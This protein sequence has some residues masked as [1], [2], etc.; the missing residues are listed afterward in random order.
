VRVLEQIK[1]DLAHDELPVLL[2]G[3]GAGFVYSHL[4]TSHQSTE[5]IACLRAVPNVTIFS[6]ADAAEL[7]ICFDHA[8]RWSGTSYMRIGKADLASVHDAPIIDYHLGDLVP[9]RRAA[10]RD[11][12]LIA[13]GSMVSAAIRIA[14]DL[15]GAE[16]WSVPTL[17]PLNGN[18]LV[19]IAK[20]ARTIVTL[21]EHSVLGGLGAAVCE[22]LSERAPTHVVRIGVNDRFSKLCGTYEYLLREHRLDDAAIA[23]RIR[24]ARER[25]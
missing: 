2:L 25:A 1:L 9:V 4:G 18:Q 22:I 21:E 6:P 11:L 24:E 12:S 15:T 17:K 3:D 16:V 10:V 13:T 8:I 5:D 19:D 23:T 14:Q 7:Q 20:E